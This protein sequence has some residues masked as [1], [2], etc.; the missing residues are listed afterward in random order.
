[1][2]Y[3]FPSKEWLLAL[4]GILNNNQEYQEA[5]KN[6]EGDFYFIIEPEGGLKERVIAYMD[7]WHGKCRSASIINDE[8]EKQPE[9]RM[10]APLSKWRRVFEKKLNPIHGMMTGQ[11]KVSGNM[12][13]IV[14]NPKAALALVNCCGLVPTI[15]PDDD[16]G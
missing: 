15:Y 2:S 5:A 10:R 1:V 4:V 13:K 16:S 12:R 3:L 9:F 6:W 11:L 7:L 8:K 14:K